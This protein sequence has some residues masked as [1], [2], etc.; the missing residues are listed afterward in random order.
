MEIAAVCCSAMCHVMRG[1]R[2][3]ESETSKSVELDGSSENLKALHA[4]KVTS[5]RLRFPIERDV[6]LHF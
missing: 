6:L 2:S 1:W 3:C 4:I 5:S